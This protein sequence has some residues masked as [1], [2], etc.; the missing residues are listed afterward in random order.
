MLAPLLAHKPRWGVYFKYRLG[1]T[2]R[3]FKVLLMST[4]ITHA[5]WRTKYINNK[6]PKT[7]HENIHIFATFTKA[8]VCAPA[9]I[10]KNARIV[11][12]FL[13]REYC[14]RNKLWISVAFSHLIPFKRATP[15]NISATFSSLWSCK[16]FGCMPQA[17]IDL[18]FCQTGLDCSSDVS[19]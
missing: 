10:E 12:F 2:N 9:Y 5:S 18:L 3:I 13:S 7:K 17:S 15:S 11:F 4:F 8:C 14:E 1:C 6:R 19:P 16:A